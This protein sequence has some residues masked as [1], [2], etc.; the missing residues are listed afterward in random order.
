MG[1]NLKELNGFIRN[2]SD[3]TYLLPAYTKLIDLQTKKVGDIILEVNGDK[4][5]SEED[6]ISVLVDSSPGDILKLKVYRD[7]KTM[8]VSMKLERS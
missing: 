2:N 8:D 5:K 4:V 1:D 6:I 3:A 7:K